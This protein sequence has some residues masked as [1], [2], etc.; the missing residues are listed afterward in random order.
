VLPKLS[1]SKKKAEHPNFGE[2]DLPFIV[3]QEQIASARHQT[4]PIERK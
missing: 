4:R 1:I 2:Q 3:I